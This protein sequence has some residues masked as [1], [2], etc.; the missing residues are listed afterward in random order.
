MLTIHNYDKIKHANISLNGQRWKV[1]DVTER[2]YWYEFAIA[3]HIDSAFVINQ[4]Q[5]VKIHRPEEANGFEYLITLNDNASRG[6]TK[7]HKQ[8]IKDPKDLLNWI[9]SKY[10]M[11]INVC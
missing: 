1:L 3:P 9:S 10:L 4:S 7:I 11:N 5:F 2:E 6:L 8:Y